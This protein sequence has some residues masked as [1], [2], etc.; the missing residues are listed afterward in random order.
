MK[1]RPGVSLALTLAALALNAAAQEVPVA[2]TVPALSSS[3]GPAAPALADQQ[4]ALSAPDFAA[5]PLTPDQ[6]DQLVGPIA[7]YPD[8]LIAV[9]LPAATTP[10]D[11]VLAARYLKDGGDPSIVD[12]HSWEESVK[13]LAHYPS[14]VKWMDDNLTWTKQLGE[15]FREQPDDVMQAIQRLRAVA[16]AAGALANA[17]QQLV[18]PEE[19]YIRIVPAQPTVIYVPVYDP[20]YV[21]DGRP[22]YYGSPFLSFTTG[23]A[24]G[25][26]LT[27][28]CDWS[29][30]QVW[31]VDR[32]WSWRDHRD[33]RHP[34]FPGQP[35]Y[36]STPHRQPWRPATYYPRGTAPVFG[37]Q[38]NSPVHANP[39]QR[40]SFA[41][42]AAEIA[43]DR[44]QPPVRSRDPRGRR[45]PSPVVASPSVPAPQAAP[46]STASP[47]PRVRPDPVNR[48]FRAGNPQEVAATRPAPTPAPNATQQLTFTGAPQSER[49]FPLNSPPSTRVVAPFVGPIVAP[50]A[51]P[52]APAQRVPFPAVTNGASPFV[53]QAVP[54]RAAPP[55]PPATPP[56]PRDDNNRDNDRKNKVQP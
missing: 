27:Y 55:P 9:I 4:Y 26:W 5:A 16:R 38:N 52:P 11:L 32:R 6:L 43:S 1:T 49:N 54:P 29:H 40:P 12:N 25:A 13:A 33:W 46:I 35:G 30:R 28:D 44:G 20:A 36:V 17:P 34:V 41:P 39:A 37:W 14:V 21:F 48:N 53:P 23:F 3:N 7:L 22:S 8:A 10:V 51:P 47:A 31:A 15:A 24:V 19:D 45:P 2:P 50:M 42:R 18:I 56:A